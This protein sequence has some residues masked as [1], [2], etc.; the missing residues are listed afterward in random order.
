NLDPEMPKITMQAPEIN[1]ERLLE[2]KIKNILSNGAKLTEVYNY[3]FVSEDQLKKLNIELSQT[4]KLANSLSEDLTIL[5]PSLIPSLLKNIKINQAKYENINLFEI[6]N[7]FLNL[8]GDINK[9]NESKET[10]PKQEKYLGIVVAASK[11]NNLFY[12]IKGIVEYLMNNF[13]LEVNFEPVEIYQGWAD[14]KIIAQINVSNKNIGIVAQLDNQIAENLGIKK[15]VAVAEINFQKL[16]DLISSTQEKNYK[17]L[18]KFPS[19]VRDLAF[20]VNSEILYSAIKNEIENFNNLIKQVELF[21]VY[22]GEK[23]GQNKK[24]L[25]FHIIYQASDRTLT[26]NEIDAMQAKLIKN[27]EKKFQAQIRNF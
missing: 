20:V 3:S 16:Y 27:L 14:K 10:L 18:E 4:I 1:N 21:D 13:G 25:A 8:Q 7:I 11:D 26:I 17:E 2:R 12:T 22:Q 15:Q 9:D 6:G 24:N 23:L 5:R 19:V